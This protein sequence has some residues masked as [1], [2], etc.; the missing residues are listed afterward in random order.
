MHVGHVAKTL[1]DRTELSAQ[2]IAALEALTSRWSIL[3]DLALSDLVLWV[4]TWNEAGMVAVAQI[5]PASAPTTLLEDVVGAFAPRGRFHYLDQAEALGRATIQREKGDPL[6]PAGVEAIPMLFD[7]RIIAV[8][9]RHCGGAP[10]VAGR[11]ER[12]YLESADSIFSMITSGQDWFAE[13]A[14]G[15]DAGESPRVGD[16]LVRLG[17]DGIVNFAS[18]NALS[19]FRKLGLALDLVDQNF[20]EI[21]K[22]M[23]VAPQG[24]S[25]ALTKI[26]RGGTTA[27]ADLIGEGAT[28]MLTSHY[29][30]AQGQSGG[31][32][33]CTV[34][35]IKDVTEL[36]AHQRELL[37]KD[38][39]IKEINHRVKNNLQIVASLLRL[40][41][42]RSNNVAVK[43]A[44]AEAQGRIGVIASVH[45]SL[46][47]EGVTV[48][49]FDD[50]LESLLG[51]I[52]SES[53]NFSI[54]LIGS[55]GVLS[56]GVATPLA[57]AVS[58]LLHNAAEHSSATEIVLVAER[59]MGLLRVSVSDNGT[60]AVDAEPMPLSEF[61]HCG[62]G[63]T[64]VSDLVVNELHGSVS[65]GSNPGGV[66]AHNGTLVS[67][68]IPISR[69]PAH[70]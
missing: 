1:Q 27:T 45:D 47:R 58:E 17:E 67:I 62:L 60:G 22:R 29:L 16:G 13:M 9:A 20:F 50:L 39:I 46:S 48:V 3:A 36:R 53:A 63:L 59:E 26:A 32:E 64:I 70:N 69:R 18:P 38:A 42:R 40:Q 43:E 54:R 14:H 5:R 37:S 24:L 8:I 23:S 51:L 7:G 34:I 28:L 4:P 11:L 55:F 2:A 56:S 66:D 30:H 68:S 49:D 15:L 33:K 21:V 41:G 25:I 57:M 10:R 12:V 31:D 35:V 52:E 44:L 19:A 65:I 61:S 6:S